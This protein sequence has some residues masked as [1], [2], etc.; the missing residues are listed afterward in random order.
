MDTTEHLL[1]LSR[2]LEEKADEARV[3]LSQISDL[4]IRVPQRPDSVYR[5][6]VANGFEAGGN[7]YRHETAWSICNRII[8][9]RGALARLAGELRCEAEV[10]TSVADD[11]IG[12]SGR[13][14]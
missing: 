9:Q 2:Q 12:A 13:L 6:L 8:D 11:S 5:E 1:K 10:L 7:G 3:I 14:V 4:P